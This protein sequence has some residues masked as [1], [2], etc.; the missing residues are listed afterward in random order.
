[1]CSRALIITLPCRH[2][3]AFIESGEKG[4]GRHRA[5]GRGNI[6]RQVWREGPEEGVYIFHLHSPADMASQRN[7]SLDLQNSQ[8]SLS[9]AVNLAVILHWLAPFHLGDF[10]SCDFNM[11]DWQRRSM[12]R[13]PQKLNHLTSVK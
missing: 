6:E 11:H 8:L 9:N 3:Q 10:S 13:R 4:R 2:R 12:H 1:M 7:L 5:E